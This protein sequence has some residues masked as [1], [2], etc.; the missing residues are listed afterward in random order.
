MLAAGDMIAFEFDAKQEGVALV[1]KARPADME[2]AQA[3]DKT[4][5]EWNSP[6]DE[7]AYG[8]L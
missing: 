1:R 4:L 3:L 6:Y 7:E 2:F 5:S 8:D